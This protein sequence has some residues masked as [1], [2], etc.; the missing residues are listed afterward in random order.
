ME[1]NRA[2]LDLIK[3]LLNVCKFRSFQAENSLTLLFFAVLLC[4][5]TKLVESVLVRFDD[6]VV[7]VQHLNLRI[8]G[9]KERKRFPIL[10]FNVLSD[11]VGHQIV[12]VVSAVL[13]LLDTTL[14]CQELYSFSIKLLLVLVNFAVQI[15]HAHRVNIDV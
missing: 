2:L 11:L 4:L 15:L 1:S 13:Q 9:I 10:L 12:R 14:P 3:N 7:F 6:L 5:Q 8:V